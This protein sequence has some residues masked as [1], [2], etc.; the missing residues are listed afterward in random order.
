M[1][2]NSIAFLFGFLPLT[3][4][5]HAAS[6]FALRNLT[7]LLCSLI[8]YF[9]GE[10]Y[11]VFILLS[12]ISL[13]YCIGLLLP[14]ALAR[15]KRVARCVLGLGISANLLL[16]FIYKYL[17]FFAENLE[18]LFKS[19]GLTIPQT[20]FVLPIGISFFTFQALSY[21]VDVYRQEVPAERNPIGLALYISLFPQLIAGPIVRYS[22]IAKQIKDRVLSRSSFSSGARRFIQG[23]SKKVLLAD[24]LAK[25]VD[26]IFALPA[27]E[28]TMSLAWFA[29]F[30]YS[31]QIYLDFS[32]YSDMAIGLGR[33]FGFTFLEN[34]NFP[35]ISTSLRE[36]WR[37]WHISL[38][39]WFRDYLYIP[40]GG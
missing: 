22:T 35:Y 25:M 8:F 37:R 6:P 13:N 16:L 7:L 28:L 4:L 36:F 34:F 17:G 11:F 39:T 26:L 30:A 14:V 21:L 20:E 23:L 18:P 19:V 1:L 15:S 5:L 3:L 10:G 40:L 31:L 27:E 2:F 32:G 12:S 33:M 24:P 38:S 29:A 9:W